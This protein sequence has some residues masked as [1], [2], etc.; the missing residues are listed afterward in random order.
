MAENLPAT[1]PEYVVLEKDMEEL[2]EVL[3]TNIGS[4][5]HITSFDLDRVRI[6]TAGGLQWTVPDIDGDQTLKELRGIVVHFKDGRVYWEHAFGSG[7]SGPPDCA[8]PDGVTGIGNPGGNCLKCKY[9]AWESDPKGG[10]GQA[11][12]A[13]RLVFLVREGNYLPLVLPLPPTSLQNARRYF[14][15]LAGSG[16][17]YYGVETRWTLEQAQNSGGIKYSRAVPSVSRRLA[18]EEAARIKAYRSEIRAALERISI[19]TDDYTNGEA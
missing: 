1:K 13:L 17:P 9:A 3:R 8:S 14:L 5:G 2:K 19:E 12:K 7:P 16:V 4:D 15:R 10:R 6:P 18:Q 11:C